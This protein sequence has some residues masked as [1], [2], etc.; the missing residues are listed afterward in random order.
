MRDGTS[1]FEARESGRMEKTKQSEYLAVEREGIVA[2]EIVN[3]SEI[4]GNPSGREVV[5]SVNNNRNSFNATCGFKT[6][7]PKMPRFAGDVRDYA[8][9]RSDFKQVVGTRCSK[10]DTISFLRSSL[11]GRPLE[12]IKGIVYRYRL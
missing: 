8:I 2:N 10:R 11:Q 3:E 9:F 4:E 7:K 12:L 5:S 1:E 6:E